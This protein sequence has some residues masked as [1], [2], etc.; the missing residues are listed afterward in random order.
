[1]SNE[2]ELSLR[3]DD[4]EAAA[5]EALNRVHDIQLTLNELSNQFRTLQ[6]DFDIHHRS[7]GA[8]G[9]IIKV[10]VNKLISVVREGDFDSLDEEEFA[11]ELTKLFYEESD[12]LPF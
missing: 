11:R 2:N 6:Y 3:C 10:M 9:S 1:M 8:M 5:V 12:F 7:E 4:I